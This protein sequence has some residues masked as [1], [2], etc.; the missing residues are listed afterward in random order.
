[1]FY[2]SILILENQHKSC[3]MLDLNKDLHINI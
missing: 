2:R 3:I 1:M